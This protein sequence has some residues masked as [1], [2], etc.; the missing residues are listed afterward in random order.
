[1]GVRTGKKF[2]MGDTVQIKLVSANLEKRQLDFDWIP[3][4]ESLKKK[5]VK[6]KKKKKY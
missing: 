4:I 2:R 6:S 1:V 3:G 5:A